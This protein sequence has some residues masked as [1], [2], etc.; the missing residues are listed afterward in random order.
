MKNK[1]PKGAYNRDPIFYGEIM[2]I[3]VLL[4]KPKVGDKKKVQYMCLGDFSGNWETVLCIC[5]IKRE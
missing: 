3:G 4:D 2:T 5:E 1:E